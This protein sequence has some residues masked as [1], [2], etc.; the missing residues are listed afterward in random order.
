MLL[1]LLIIL[2]ISGSIRWWKKYRRIVATFSFTVKHQSK[3]TGNNFFIKAYELISI[4]NPTFPLIG[5][6]G[7]SFAAVCQSLTFASSSAFDVLLF[8][9]RSPLQIL[10][11]ITFL[12]GNASLEMKLKIPKLVAV[13]TLH[14]SGGQTE[15][16]WAGIC[17]L[18]SFSINWRF[19]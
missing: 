10:N 6:D 14:K 2:H 8:L 17:E 13:L 12:R 5:A 15:K 7:S 1:L 3:G 18:I 11:W 4:S 16:L 9:V 19:I